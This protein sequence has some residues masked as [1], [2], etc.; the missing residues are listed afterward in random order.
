MRLR[1]EG[2]WCMWWEIRSW[3]GLLRSLDLSHGGLKAGE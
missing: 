1:Y 3:K 2:I